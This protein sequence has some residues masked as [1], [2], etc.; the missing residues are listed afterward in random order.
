MRQVQSGPL[1]AAADGPRASR[2]RRRRP[3]LAPLKGRDEVALVPSSLFFIGIHGS[4]GGQHLIIY[5]PRLHKHRP[6]AEITSSGSSFLRLL[7]Q[8]RR[9]RGIQGRTARAA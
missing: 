7:L 3:E 6:Q 4:T 1:A 9:R 5:S 2:R 8:S